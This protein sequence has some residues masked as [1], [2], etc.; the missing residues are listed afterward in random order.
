MFSVCGCSEINN[1]KLFDTVPPSE[2]M[3]ELME[4][5]RDSDIIKYIS[6]D[7]DVRE[8]QYCRDFLS[9]QSSLNDNQRNKICLQEFIHDFL[10]IE[11]NGYDYLLMNYLQCKGYCDHGCSIR[12]AWTNEPEHVP[13]KIRK[14]EILKWVAA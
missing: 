8:V 9:M 5:Y 11:H 14:S 7:T 1:K 10:F 6:D 12:C 4:A 3:E 13:N 2:F